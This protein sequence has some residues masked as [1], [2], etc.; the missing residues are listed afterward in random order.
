MSLA[1]AIS[2]AWQPRNQ[3]EKQL[4]TFT[5]ALVISVVGWLLLIDPALRGR[6]YWQQELPAMKEA[7]SQMRYLSTEI[8]KL[9]VKTHGSGV[10]LSRQALEASLSDKGI[11]AD[12]LEITDSHVNAHFVDISFAS[13][14]ELLKQ[15][16]ISSQLMVEE[17]TVTARDR[18]DRV[19]VRV[20]LKRV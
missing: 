11:K 1:T 5:G 20:S 6:A 15:W 16:Q 7:I 2:K 10:G 17:I 12:T 8:G 9:P 14:T 3:R 19:D 4:L 13:F 18:I